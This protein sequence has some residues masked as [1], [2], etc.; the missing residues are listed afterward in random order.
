MAQLRVDPVRHQQYLQSVN[1][2]NAAYPMVSV[3]TVAVAPSYAEVVPG[4][5]VVPQA[6]PQYVQLKPVAQPVPQPQQQQQVVVA[7]DDGS[8]MV[9]GV[10]Y[11]PIPSQPQTNTTTTSAAAVLPMSMETR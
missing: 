9:G 10:R 3:P 8:I 4:Y 5:A 11:A 1:G 6:E 2:T 7:N